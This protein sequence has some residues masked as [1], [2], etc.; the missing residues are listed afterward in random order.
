MIA[1]IVLDASSG[2]EFWWFFDRAL[3]KILGM[4]SLTMQLDKVS[5]RAGEAL[6]DDD[7]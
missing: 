5:A 6:S 7:H 2:Q 1:A 3:W 4:T